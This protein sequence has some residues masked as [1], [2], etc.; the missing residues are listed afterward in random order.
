MTQ[1][2][3]TKKLTLASALRLEFA[4]IGLGIVALFMIFQPFSLTVFSLGCGLVVVA[5]L[6]NNLLPLAEVGTPVR[7]IFWAAT[8]VFLIFFTALLVSIV[9]AHLYGLFFL[10]APTV[11][12]LVS[13][14]PAK[15]FWAQPLVWGI[16]AIDFVLWLV[17]KRLAGK[18]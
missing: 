11:S 2:P 7:K 9:A 1:K 5:A 13:A 6:V 16:A 15:P 8:V 3:E 4:I 18:T 17:V 12:L 10:K 14:P